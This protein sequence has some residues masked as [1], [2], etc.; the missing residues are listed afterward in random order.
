[1]DIRIYNVLPQTAKNIRISVFLD[2]QGFKEEFDD[3]DGIAKHIVIFDGEK[4]IATCRYFFSTERN[5]YLIGRVAVLPEYRKQHIGA[6]LLQTAE[7][8]IAKSGG[9]TVEL[10]AQHTAV[11]FYEK[12]GYINLHDTH[13]EEFCLHTWMRKELS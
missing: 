11:G 10:S 1:M 9:K 7:N 8:E 12:Q 4:A 5:C 2:E 3:I 6:K 13:Y